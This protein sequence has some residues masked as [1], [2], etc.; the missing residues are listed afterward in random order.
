MSDLQ[1]IK[2]PLISASDISFIRNDRKILHDVSFAILPEQIITVIGPNGAGKSTLIKILLGILKP[3]TGYV[4]KRS[5]VIVSYLAQKIKSDDSM[6]LTVTR[7]L[8]LSGCKNKAE[9]KKVLAEVGVENLYKADFHALSGG[10]TQRVLLARC[11]LRKPNLLILDEPTQGLDFNG[12]IEL[13][14]LLKKIRRRYKCAIVIISHDLHLVMDATDEVICLNHH[15]CCSGKPE[16]IKNTPFFQSLFPDGHL[17][18]IAFYSHH[19]NHCHCLNGEEK[20]ACK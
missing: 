1:Q 14:H 15:I 19:H 5:D 3:D 7:L 8:A 20:E 2:T 9:H 6:P 10:E 11:L 13:Y 12:G 17:Q 18:D 16:H 4:E